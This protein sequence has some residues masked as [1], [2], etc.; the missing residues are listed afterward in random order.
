MYLKLNNTNIARC[1][2]N[3]K[4]LTSVNFFGEEIMAATPKSF[5]EMYSGNT[6]INA[7]PEMD[8]YRANNMA[9]LFAY[10]YDIVNTDAA[11]NY[12]TN[13]VTNIASIFNYCDNISNLDLSRWNVSKI[14]NATDAFRQCAKLSS[15]NLNGWHMKDA[16]ISRMLAYC[17]NLSNINWDN[18][19][20]DNCNFK[21]LF[22]NIAINPSLNFANLNISGSAAGIF[23]GSRSTELNL[24]SLNVSRITNMSNMLSRSAL[25]KNVNVTG[26]DTGNVTNLS[27][28]FFNTASRTRGG[29]ITSIAGIENWDV[30]NVTDFSS[31]FGGQV[32]IK[33]HNLSNWNVSKGI[34]FSRMFLNGIALTSLN[35]VEQWN[36]INGQNFSSM[37]AFCNKITSLNLSKWNVS[38]GINLAALFRGMSNLTDLDLTN[39]DLSNTNS[40]VYFVYQCPKLKNLSGLSS[41][42]AMPNLRNAASAFSGCQNLVNIDLSNWRINNCS[43]C[44]IFSYCNNLTSIGDA[45]KLQNTF[46]NVI[47]KSA[48]QGTNININQLNNWTF[49]NCTDF[50]DMFADMQNLT[51]VNLN[52]TFD[53]AAQNFNNMFSNCINLTSIDLHNQ[54]EGVY[55]ERMFNNC[56]NLITINNFSIQQDNVKLNYIFHNCFN[57]NYPLVNWVHNKNIASAEYAFSNFGGSIDNAIFNGQIVNLNNA[58][59]TDS[60]K[61]Q[62]CNIEFGGKETYANGIFNNM[63]NLQYLNNIKFSNINAYNTYICSNGAKLISIDGFTMNNVYSS[64]ENYIFSIFNNC[65]NLTSINNI[66]FLRGHFLNSKYAFHAF[67][68]CN[69]IQSITNFTIQ[70][71]DFPKHIFGFLGNVHTIDNMYINNTTSNFVYWSSNFNN[72]QNFNNITISYAPNFS[73]RKT[74]NT[75]SDFKI[76]NI[77]I[78][79]VPNI[80]W[81]SSLNATNIYN[82]S[83]FNITYL[84]NI[85]THPSN[86]PRIK[87]LHIG[88][89]DMKNTIT[90]DEMFYDNAYNL[91]SLYWPNAN[92]QSLINASYA[93]YNTR[94][95][96][97][98]NLTNWNMPKLT[99]RLPLS[100]N[101]TNLININVANWNAPNVTSASRLFNNSRKLTTLDLSS[102]NVP[103]ISNWTYSFSNCP[104]LT[105]LKLNCNI[106]AMEN[107]AY[108]FYN[109]TNL[110]E[111][112][113]NLYSLANNPNLKDLSWLFFNQKNWTQ[114]L[115]ALANWNLSNVTS[116]AGMFRNGPMLTNADIFRNWDLQNVTTATSLFTGQSN[117]ISNNAL[118]NLNLSKCN[119][120]AYIFALCSNITELNI[121]NWG[122]GK[123]FWGAQAFYECANLKTIGDISSWIGPS[124]SMYQMFLGCKNLTS[125]GDLSNWDMSTLTNASW[126]FAEC[127]NLTSLGDLSN[128]NMNN[129]T[130]IGG[131]FF[132]CNNLTS[133]GNISQWNVSKVTTLSQTFSNCEKLISVND[134]SGW[135][136][137]NVT[138]LDFTFY[139]C[140]HLTSLQ[141]LANWN[142]GKVTSYRE[143]FANSGLIDINGIQNWD[144]SNTTE[145]MSMFAHCYNLTEANLAGMNMPQLNDITWLF[146]DCPSLT[147]VNM[148]NWNIPAIYSTQDLFTNCTNLTTLDITGWEA[149]HLNNSEYVTRGFFTAPNLTTIKG[150]FQN[151]GNNIY[152]GGSGYILNLCNCPQLTNTSVMN[153]V[154]G[155][156][157]VSNR[158]SAASEQFLIFLNSSAYARITS[159]DLNRASEKGWFIKQR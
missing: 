35:T 23:E 140:K 130:D 71:W 4:Q 72:L 43:L 107:L 146:S 128:W 144:F 7:C 153:L 81:I 93:F 123:K 19:L 112:P 33:E 59:S 156:A 96:T 115:D 24:T 8:T 46:D 49:T 52:W 32:K 137:S 16:N 148:A 106:A 131:L 76:M 97:D 64:K 102:W 5:A 31:A 11:T 142:V 134:L 108:M 80:A 117:M 104:N 37:F 2:L 92:F 41:W 47:F 127:S 61:T 17:N 91:Q 103:K 42:G 135:D 82:L 67:D 20:F 86:G 141:N 125:I 152:T 121:T 99:G 13:F 114:N 100:G 136:T 85:W 139:Q 56:Q 45:Q 120:F 57:L 12:Y 94:G 29:N 60:V 83:L 138:D 118:I 51:S 28:I 145:I 111:C 116:I 84:N 74:N 18:T 3:G 40:L 89:C 143:T 119:T 159:D 101:F 21:Q 38:N 58:F 10:C 79:N 75:A 132:G 78:G 27:G 68:E 55:K 9:L 48:F 1:Y 110:P 15:I 69:N 109:T 157:D 25:L 150:S 66:A 124:S 155:F 149:G 126:T 147:S 133:I 88:N 6:I 95:L 62:L 151:L 34:N 113:L 63:S 77:S 50:S 158:S 70:D 65:N 54:F 53:N 98:L 36:V 44:G 87:S 30:S 129:C 26:W 22:F 73:I 90:I 14:T 122:S 39:W 105:T 154:N